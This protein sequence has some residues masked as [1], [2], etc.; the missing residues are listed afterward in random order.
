MRDL[1]S[2]VYLA[3]VSKIQQYSTLHFTQ[4]HFKFLSQCNYRADME[5]VVEQMA[6]MAHEGESQGNLTNYHT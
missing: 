3:Y 2:P 5:K 6:R 1:E 4:C